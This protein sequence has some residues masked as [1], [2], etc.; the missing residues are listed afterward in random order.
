MNFVLAVS[1]TGVADTAGAGTGEPAAAGAAVLPNSIFSPAVSK[2]DKLT[3]DRLALV[4][5]FPWA[6]VGSA[7]QMPWHARAYDMLFLWTLVNY[8]KLQ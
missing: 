7:W 6:V 8:G 2:Q 1:E 3:K 4:G 5:P